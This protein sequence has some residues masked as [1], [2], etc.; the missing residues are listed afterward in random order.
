MSYRSASTSLLGLLALSAGACAPA[1]TVRPID[2]NTAYQCRLQAMAAS[3]EN[4]PM[5]RDLYNQCLR[6]HG[7]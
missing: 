3:N 7:E 2:T 6:A 1:P 4:W 5:E